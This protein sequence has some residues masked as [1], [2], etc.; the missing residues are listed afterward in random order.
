MLCIQSTLSTGVHREP[1][2]IALMISLGAVLL[3]QYKLQ[4]TRTQNLAFF[5]ALFLRLLEPQ[6]EGLK[7]YDEEN[8]METENGHDNHEHASGA[9]CAHDDEKRVV[10][11]D[12]DGNAMDVEGDSEK[13]G[14]S[15][16]ESRFGEMKLSTVQ[17]T[18]MSLLIAEERKMQKER[19]KLL[20]AYLPSILA[21]VE[22]LAP[23]SDKIGSDSFDDDEDFANRVFAAL[24]NLLPFLLPSLKRFHEDCQR[25]M[26]LIRRVGKKYAAREMN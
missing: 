24:V 15:K 6:P 21:F 8:G 25:V 17:N 2:Q 11:L 13:G 3:K 5:L 20:Q 10:E 4:K 1:H 16:K 9:C 14:S 18:D 7:Q 22:S 23:V 19:E 12:E 26:N